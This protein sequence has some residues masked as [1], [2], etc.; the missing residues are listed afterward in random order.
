MAIYSLWSIS[1]VPILDELT[2]Q[3]LINSNIES[4]KLLTS[5]IDSKKRQRYLKVTFEV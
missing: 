5:I 2:N 4:Q 3:Y 1:L